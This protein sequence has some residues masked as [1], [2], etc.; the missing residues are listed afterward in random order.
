MTVTLS[1]GTTT[2][3]LDPDLDW[4][5]EYAWSPVVQNSSYSLTGALIVQVSTRQAGRPITLAGADDRGWMDGTV[6]AQLQAWAAV[7]G[8]TLTLTLRG[9]AYSVMLRHQDAPAVEATPVV[10]YSD[11]NSNDWYVATLKFMVI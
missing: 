3:T 9:V 5:D 11:P 6:I 4:S 1:D 10:G 7:A 2:L 8:K